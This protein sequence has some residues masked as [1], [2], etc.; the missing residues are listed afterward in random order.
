MLVVVVAV[1][2]AVV[3]VAAVA[4]EGEIVPKDSSAPLA[5]RLTPRFTFS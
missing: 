5:E 3:V 2:E 4:V 1:V